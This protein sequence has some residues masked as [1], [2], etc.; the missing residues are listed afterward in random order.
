MRPA[1]PP[2]PAAAK[3]YPNGVYSGYEVAMSQAGP[4]DEVVQAAG[5]KSLAKK[6]YQKPEVRHERVFETMALA[7]GKVQSTSRA[8]SHTRKNS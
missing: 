2:P 8:C 3:A 6:P 1:D 4:K 7:C 5:S